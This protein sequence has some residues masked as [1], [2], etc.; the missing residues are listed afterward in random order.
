MNWP[1]CNLQ[2]SKFVLIDFAPPKWQNIFH[3]KCQKN[4]TFAILTFVIVIEAP[5][6]PK[7]LLSAIL[8]SQGVGKCKR[9]G[10]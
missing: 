9:F 5:S 10:H 2:V 4:F 3:I 6:M 7:Y 1:V 8:S